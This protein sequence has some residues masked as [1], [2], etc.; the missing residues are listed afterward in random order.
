MV[1]VGQMTRLGYEPGGVLRVRCAHHGERSTQRIHDLLIVAV[2]LQYSFTP[3][4]PVRWHLPSGQ[5]IRQLGRYLIGARSG[6][7]VPDGADAVVRGY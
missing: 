1:A 5:V 7:N 6:R 2:L 4:A 3:P